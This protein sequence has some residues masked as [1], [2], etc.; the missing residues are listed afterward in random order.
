MTR[1]E[2]A[3]ILAILKA[4]YPESYKSLKMR[5]GLAM[6]G[7]WQNMFDREPYEMVR[8]A[9]L[10]LI[11]TRKVGYSPTVGEVK[12]KLQSIQEKD[13][14]SEQAAWAMVS[15][16]CMNGLYGYREEYAKLPPEVQRALGAPEQLRAWAMVDVDTFESVVASN[17]MRSYR[18]QMF[19]EKETAM[20]PTEIRNL[21]G[22]VSDNLKMIGDGE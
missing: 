14:L 1:D 11:A 2:A 12:E 7:L 19:R 17:F 13:L 6:I 8:A 4:A 22:G 9:V 21:L 20:L 16:A 10:A 3:E 5:D 18:A 15:K